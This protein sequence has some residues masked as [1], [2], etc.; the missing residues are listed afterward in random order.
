MKTF[1]ILMMLLVL[2]LAFAAGCSDDDPR[3]PCPR[4]IRG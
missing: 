2:A 1:P 4:S 3:A